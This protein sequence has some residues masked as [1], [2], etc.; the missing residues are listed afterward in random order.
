M[1]YQWDGIAAAILAAC[2]VA[3]W[4]TKIYILGLV[5]VRWWA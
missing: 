1:L 2:V 5:H 3:K 4:K